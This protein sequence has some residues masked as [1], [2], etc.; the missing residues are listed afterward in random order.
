MVHRHHDLLSLQAKLHGHVLQGIDRG[1]INAGLT[2]LAQTT[3]AHGHAKAIEQTFERCRAAVHGRGLH[4]LGHKQA[5][6]RLESLSAHGSL[7]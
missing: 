4:Y 1:P 6:A 5:T 7:V 3:I 2:R